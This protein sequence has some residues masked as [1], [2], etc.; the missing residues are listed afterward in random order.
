ML[1]I[2]N[3]NAINCHV[4]CRASIP[5]CIEQFMEFW[6]RFTATTEL[7]QVCANTCAESSILPWKIQLTMVSAVLI[8]SNCSHIRLHRSLNTVWYSV[9]LWSFFQKSFSEE[10]CKKFTNPLILSWFHMW[11]CLVEIR[12]FITLYKGTER[13]DSTI[14]Y[15]I[16]LLKCQHFKISAF[17]DCT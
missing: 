16:I 1:I 6:A 14:F 2:V 5:C 11:R 9:L 8:N 10:K 12:R 15:L 7:T 13:K 3:N 4:S 17:Q